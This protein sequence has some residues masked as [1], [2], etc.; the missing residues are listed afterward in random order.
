M[1]QVNRL[2]NIF[3]INSFYDKNIYFLRNFEFFNINLII[4]SYRIYFFYTIFRTIHNL[5]QHLNRSIMRF[6]VFKLTSFCT[7][8]NT[9]TNKLNLSFFKYRLDFFVKNFTVYF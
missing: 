2:G 3:K 4:D 7:N 6:S 9:D 5:S 1:S 8:N